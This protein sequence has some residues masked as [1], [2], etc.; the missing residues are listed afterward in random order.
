M[1]SALQL[2]GAFLIIFSCISVVRHLRQSGFDIGDA[3]SNGQLLAMA[4]MIVIG[5]GLLFVEPKK[6]G[7]GE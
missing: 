6:K 4:V 3:Y 2:V 5:I 1:K 7:D